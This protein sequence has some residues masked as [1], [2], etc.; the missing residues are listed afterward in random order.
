MTK[1]N[2]QILF[3]LII[4]LVFGI[5][6]VFIFD[7]DCIFKKIFHIPCPGCGLTRGFKALLKGNILLAF[8]YNILTIPICIFL[9]TAV[10]LL[11]IDYIQ[12]EKYLQKFFLIL[13][14]NYIFIII[15]LIISFITNIINNV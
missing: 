14:K 6:V 1:F 15:I 11:I 8:N 4:L 7:V 3:L 12:K 13:K 10:T 2:K 5:L 9:L